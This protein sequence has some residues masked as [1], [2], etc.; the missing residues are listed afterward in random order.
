MNREVVKELVE[1]LT[2]VEN[3]MKLL[4]EDKKMIVD[5]FKDRLDMK[6]FMA[7]WQ[8]LKKRERVDEAVLDNLLHILQEV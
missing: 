1:K 7:A 3:E 4:R 6:A 8:I 2:R 5:D